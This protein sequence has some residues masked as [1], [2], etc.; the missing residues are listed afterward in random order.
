MLLIDGS[1][2]DWLER[3]DGRYKKLCLLGAVDDATGKAVHLRFW[4]TEC[5]AGYITLAREVATNPDY[6]IPMSFYHDRHTILCSPKEQTIDDELA[7]REPQSQ[8]EAILSQLGAES[9][10]ALTPQAKGRIERMWQTLQD[11]LIKEMRLAGVSTMDEANAFLPRFLKRYNDRFAV[12]PRD[13][14]TAWV[15]PE[16]G[17]EE[18]DLPSLFAAKEE[19]TVRA[20]HTLAW[21]GKTLLIQRK[22]GERSLA[23]TRVQVHTTPEAECFVYHGKTRLVFTTVTERPQ[24]TTQTR[25]TPQAAAELDEQTKRTSRRKQMHFVHQGV[26]RCGLRQAGCT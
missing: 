20:D 24:Q 3:R 15:Q 19:R 9:I 13:P 26:G 25:Q 14:Q 4:P 11:R 18:L 10:K 17:G 8:F 5:Q 7:G 1:S 12:Q 22:R 6:G 16:Q 21:Q 23:R 2:H